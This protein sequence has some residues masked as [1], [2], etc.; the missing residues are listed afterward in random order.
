MSID[1]STA[2]W[3]PNEDANF[4]ILELIDIPGF[5]NILVND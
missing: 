5:E 2:S 3:D 4:A 1:L